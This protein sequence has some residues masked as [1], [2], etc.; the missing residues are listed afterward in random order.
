MQSALKQMY[1]LL[2]CMLLFKT[3]FW[4]PSSISQ[5]SS[6]HGKNDTEGKWYE[7]GKPNSQAIRDFTPK[8]PEQVSPDSPL[9]SFL[10]VLHKL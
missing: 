4:L 3:L 9:K 7:K 1:K 6:Y 2:T 8:L 5:V 10:L